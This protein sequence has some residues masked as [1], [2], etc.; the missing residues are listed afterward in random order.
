MVAG[1]F[2]KRL[3]V[4][5]TLSSVLALAACE[6]LRPSAEAQSQGAASE[7]GVSTSAGWPSRL[8]AQAV[9]DE[10]RRIADY[11]GLVS[12]DGNRLTVYYDGKP[13]FT[14][15]SDPEHCR[16]DATCDVWQFDSGIVLR[17]PTTGK[18]ETYAQLYH[19][20]GEGGHT[21]IVTRDGKEFDLYSPGVA[22]PD[23]RWIA[24]G[25]DWVDEYVDGNV[26]GVTDWTGKV[27]TVLFEPSC[28]PVAWQDNDRFSVRCTISGQEAYHNFEG[29]V[30]RGS[31]GAW[32]LTVGKIA[33]DTPYGDDASASSATTPD[34][35]PKTYDSK[36]EPSQPAA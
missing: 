16:G 36:P 11:P 29:V 5:V 6:R 27:P 1:G 14:R 15:T 2:M 17:D 28:A 18:Q 22:S 3:I 13:V 7:S 23:G 34:P 35:L 24:F 25:D 32:R 31:K 10:A 12:R 19:S 8:G 20:L 26:L 9:T 21:V 30:A 4:I 33:A